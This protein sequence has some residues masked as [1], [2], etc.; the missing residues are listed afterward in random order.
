MQTLD[1]MTRSG[2]S[3]EAALEAYR[4]WWA[5]VVTAAIDEGVANWT[6]RGPAA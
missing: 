1:G 4:S 5:T 2:W 3:V 6:W